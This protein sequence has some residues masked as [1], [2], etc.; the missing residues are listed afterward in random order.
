MLNKRAARQLFRLLCAILAGV[1]AVFVLVAF[2]APLG[3]VIFGNLGSLGSSSSSFSFVLKTTLFTLKIALLSTL[4]AFVLGVGGAFFCGTRSFWGRR[5]LLSFS[6][7]PLCIPPLITALGYVSFFGMNGYF[8]QILKSALALDRSPIR[9]LYS[10]AGIIICQGFYNFPLVLSIVAQAWKNSDIQKQNAARLLGAGEGRVFFTVTLPSLF[11]AMA[12]A[13]I[14]VFLFCFFSFMIVLLFSAPGTSTLEVEIFRAVRNTLDT[15]SATAFAITETFTALLIVFVYS[16]ILRHYSSGASDA[17]EK[18]VNFPRISLAP[19]S[20]PLH[21][22]LESLIFIIFLLLIV[23]F[24]V[25]PL[26]GI[27]VYGFMK[28][29]GNGFVWSLSH[30][31]GLFSNKN[32]IFALTNTL[33]MAPWTGFLCTVLGFTYSV[34]F[35]KKNTFTQVLPLLSMAVSSVVLGWGVISLFHKSTPAMLVVM[36]TAIYWPVAYRQIQSRVDAIPHDVLDAGLLLS[37]GRLEVI[38]RVMIP[39]CLPTLFSAFCYCFALS[40]GDTTLPLLMGVRKFDTLS[41]YTYRLAG[42]YRFN[43]ACACATVLGALCCV[44]FYLG[45]INFAKLKGHAAR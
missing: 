8:N 34:A 2:L 22:A 37:Y 21:R 33:K 18:R 30:F 45:Q 4:T 31:S 38:F 40:C 19:Y 23:V 12:T 9:F 41:L 42:A 35:P 44:V 32:F 16:L 3:R 36:Q 13:C 25:L 1:G 7:V 17:A 24:F 28:K 26:G 11:P 15:G 29:Q 14:P 5:L 6:A 10:Q 43:Q 20:S 27:I 39:L